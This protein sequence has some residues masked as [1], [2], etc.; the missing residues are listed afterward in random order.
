MSRIGRAP[1]TVPAG[2]TITQNGNVV[3]VKGPKGELTREFVADMIIEVAD[4]TITVKRPTDNKEHRALHGLTR[5]LL[6]NMVVGVTA[7][8]SKTLE[9]NGVG[10]RAAKQGNNINLSLGFSHP[11]I[12]EPPTGITFEV[13]APNRIIVSGINK[14]VVGAMAAKIRGYRQP[15]PYKGKGIKYEGE[16]IRRKVGKAGGKKK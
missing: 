7:G 5:T 8:F 2:V 4:N 13:P 9:I 16:V 1:I 12:V 10:Y 3:T 6:N 14:E 11:V 15:E